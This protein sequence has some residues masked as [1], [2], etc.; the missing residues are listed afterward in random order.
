MRAHTHTHTHTHP[1]N[2]Q[3]RY[4]QKHILI[5]LF[6]GREDDVI[7]DVNPTTQA[8]SACL[9]ASVCIQSAPWGASLTL[10][11]LNT[12]DLPLALGIGESF[13]LSFPLLGDFTL[14]FSFHNELMQRMTA[15][16]ETMGPS[17]PR[18]QSNTELSP[19]QRSDVAADC[20]APNL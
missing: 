5:K 7:L 8:G 3:V 10:D 15:T 11:S 17:L 18:S 1:F 9:I 2:D 4:L 16:L 20:R 13:P 19:S 12:T 6:L 14:P